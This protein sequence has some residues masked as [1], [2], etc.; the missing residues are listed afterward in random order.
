MRQH[1]FEVI[2]FRSFDGFCCN[3]WRLKRNMPGEKGPVLLVHGAGVRSNIFNP[4]NARNLIDVLEEEGYD[5]WLENWRGSMECETNEWDLD[6]VG[7]NDHPA[8]VQTVCSISGS[9]SLKAIIHCQGSTSFMI[10]LMKGLVPQVKTVISNA[11]SLH[12][13]V[14]A[15]SRFKINYVLPVVKP[16]TKYLN[17]QW[18]DNPPDLKAKF[19]KT[20][21]TM[22]HWEKDT[23]VGK[24]VSF[25]YG[26]GMPALWELNNLSDTTMNWIRHEFG[27]VPMSFF[28]HI[29][30]C[31][32]AGQLVSSDGSIAYANAK[33][34]SEARIVFIAGKMNKCFCSESQEE[35]YSYFNSLRRHYHKLY[36]YD[37]YSHL[38]IF[39][40]KRSD[41]DIFPAMIRELNA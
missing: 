33:P 37:S 25:T 41:E 32:K 3:L 14:P 35:T 2:P 21:V 30:K 27:N 23:N 6:V 31:I 22:T 40:G 8:A 15:F 20:L 16:V 11:V 4:P 17:P 34:K 13:V 12:P 38:D 24:F 5:V 39:L 10:S 29:K 36:L 26:S 28:D 19:F 9:A 7:N 1:S 18:G